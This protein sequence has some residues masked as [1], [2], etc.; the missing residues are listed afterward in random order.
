MSLTKTLPDPHP[1]C[2]HLAWLTPLS[3]CEWVNFFG[4]IV[5]HFEWPLVRKIE[6]IEVIEMQSICHFI[7]YTKSLNMKIHIL[8]NSNSV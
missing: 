4:N 3:V 7:I 2:S 8:E 1:D 6:V 5:K